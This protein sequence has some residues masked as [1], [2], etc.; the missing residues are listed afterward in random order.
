MFK[1][2]Y[3]KLDKYD[4]IVLALAG[5]IL[6]MLGGVFISGFEAEYIEQA[7]NQFIISTFY[8]NNSFLP[9]PF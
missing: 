1:K 8:N 5:L 6:F 9:L 2:L 7:C 3:N 4:L